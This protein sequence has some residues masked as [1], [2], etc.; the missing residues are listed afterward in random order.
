MNMHGMHQ[1]ESIYEYEEEDEIGSSDG[2]GS[3]TELVQV[4]K[5]YNFS[6]QRNGGK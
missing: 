1:Y 4:I 3:T 2:S 6:V 5:F